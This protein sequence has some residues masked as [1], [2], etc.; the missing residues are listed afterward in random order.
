MNGE[1]ILGQVE[2]EFIHEETCATID[3][4]EC[5]NEGEECLS[6]EEIS[7]LLDMEYLKHIEKNSP[8]FFT[9][10]QNK[11]VDGSMHI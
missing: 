1:E 11:Q 8:I 7:A 4:N 9:I 6:M 10:H 2:E 5:M 3:D